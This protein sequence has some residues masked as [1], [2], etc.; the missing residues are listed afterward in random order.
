MSADNNTK[1]TGPLLAY[2]Y[3]AQATMM[4]PR[5]P[6]GNFK[7]NFPADVKPPRAG[8][9]SIH[10]SFYVKNEHHYPMELKPQTTDP[11]L[12]ITEYPEFLEPAEIAKVT[13]TFSPSVD[14][15]KPLEG[16]VWDFTKIVYSNTTG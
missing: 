15:I 14:R 12:S 16:G 11:D 8:I 2:Y 13:L 9:D 7:V 5:D 6:V 3:D 10:T 1:S 4:L